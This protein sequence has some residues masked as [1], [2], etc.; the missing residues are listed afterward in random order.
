MAPWDSTKSTEDGDG[1]V[2]GDE[3][4]TAGEWNQHIT[5]GHFPSDELNFGTDANGN[6]VVTDPTNN[7]QVVLRY[8][9]GAG[10]WEIVNVNLEL[11]NNNITGAGSVSAAN[12]PTGDN[13]VLR[14]QEGIEAGSARADG[15]DAS[16]DDD[17]MDSSTFTSVSVSFDNEFDT[18]PHIVTAIDNDLDNTGGYQPIVN[19]KTTTGFDVVFV[20]YSGQDKS[21]T[22]NAYGAQYVAT[23]GR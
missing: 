3:Q 1:T 22:T 15:V 7:D 23:N 20:D 11:N 12:P 19:N 21:G 6:P 4:L 2:D 10:Q 5:D 16:A 8:D 14:W 17:G 13:E 18:I 9:P